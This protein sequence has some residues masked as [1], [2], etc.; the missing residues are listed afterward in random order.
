MDLSNRGV[1]MNACSASVYSAYW[2]FSTRVLVFSIVFALS[3]PGWVVAQEDAAPSADAAEDL[4]SSEAQAPP[5]RLTP[6]LKEKYE[7][8]QE[9]LEEEKYEEAL[10]LFSEVLKAQQQFPDAYFDRGK[11]LAALDRHAEAIEDFS[12]LTTGFSQFAPAF[13]ETGKSLRALEEYDLALRSFSKAIEAARKSPAAFPYYNERGKLYA[14][15]GQLREAVDDFVSAIELQP[16]DAE[17]LYNRGSALQKLGARSMSIGDTAGASNL[18]AAV[19]SLSRAIKTKPDYHEAYFDRGLAKF[20]LRQ[21]DEGMEDLEKALELDPENLEYTERLAYA[22]IQRA[23]QEAQS[24]TADMTQVTADYEKSIALFSQLIRESREKLEETTAADDPERDLAPGEEDLPGDNDTDAPPATDDD[25]EML[26][27]PPEPTTEPAEDATPADKSDLDLELAAEGDEADALNLA[28]TGEE[29]EPGDAA[30]PFDLD[31][32]AGDDDAG[33]AA[34]DTSTG[35]ARGAA[36]PDL[37]DLSGTVAVDAPPEEEELTEEQIKQQLYQLLIA[38]AVAHTSLAEHLPDENQKEHYLAAIADCNAALELEPGLA[39]AFYNRGLAE[40]MM[41]DDESAMDS[42]SQALKFSPDYAEALFRRGILWFHEGEYELALADFDDA[43]QLARDARALF[44]AGLCHSEQGDYAEAVL[45]YSEA[46][47]ANPEYTLAYGNRGLAYLQLERYQRAIDD[48]N[49]LIRRD[50]EDAVS[51]YR[52]GMAQEMLGKFE[53]AIDS[54]ERATELDPE[55]TDA[56]RR[57]GEL[58]E[59]VGQPDK[60]QEHLDKARD[61]DPIE[62]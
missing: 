6:E 29:S 21:T 23:G 50:R 7:K 52:R 28:Q 27:T 13:F 54:F 59:E 15:V 10:A 4:F 49:T 16:A 45:S 9:L 43:G 32:G 3:T 51:Y 20:G 40:R 47:R 62:T 46:L 31:F 34:G 61:L 26:E 5:G 2:K 17:T 57:A 24:R 12:K 56:H 37:D 33:D 36:P 39:S 1:T 11:C 58:Y 25:A 53:K 48:F 42:F 8:G 18:A 41:G 22:C 30:A 55:L 35:P 19:A 38:R 14:D 60:A 44:W